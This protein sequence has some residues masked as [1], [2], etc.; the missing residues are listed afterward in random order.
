MEKDAAKIRAEMTLEEKA[1]FCSG[2]DFWHTKGIAR[3]GIP[4]VAVSDGPHGLR[5]TGKQDALGQSG[6]TGAV[7]FPSA[8]GTA[9]SFNRELLRE[10]GVSLGEEAQA[11][12]VRILLGPAVNIKRSPLG[13]RD[14]EYFSEDPY[15][16]GELAA[17]YIGGVQSQGVGACVKHFAAN[18]QET[19][20]LSVS[21]DMSQRTLR[22][23]YL[24]AFET[25]VKRSKPW[26]LMSSYNR[27]NGRYVQET[28]ELL[29]AIL[30]GEWG[31]DGLVM[32]DWSACDDRVASMK[33]GQDLEM[34]GGI[35]HNSHR[36]LEAVRSGRLPER[37]LDL[38]VERIL[39]VVIRVLEQHRP[40]AAYS[41]EEHHRR[42]YR[43]AL[44][45]MVLLKNEG[46][47]LPLREGSRVAFLG[48]FAKHP[49]F[50]GGGS[51]HVHPSKVDSAWKAAA[52]MAEL[53]FAQGYRTGRGA[54]ETALIA[55]AAEA[56][57][58]AE[59]AVIFAGLPE[60][61]ESEGRDRAG[62]ALPEDQNRLIA[63]V[64]AAQPNTVVVLHNGSP[65]AMPWLPQV[66]AVLE[67]Y[68]GGEAVGLA[69]AD[70]LFGRENP[71]GKLAETFPLRL[72]HTPCYLNFPGFDGSA[73]YAE[74]V[75]VGYR[76]YVSKHLP[77]LFPFGYGLSYTTF[78]YGGL[79]L[80]SAE[81][82]GEQEL[83]VTVRVKNTGGRAGREIVQLYVCP[84]TGGI[85][86]PSV[87]LKG[88]EQVEL[89][90]GEEKEV[91][92]LLPPRAFAFYDERNH[93][94]HVES[95]RY[96]V[97]IGRSSAEPALRQDVFWRTPTRKGFRVTRNTLLKE[98]A[99]HPVTCGIAAEE[100]EPLRNV[101]S[102]KP[103]ER[104]STEEGELDFD[105]GVIRD[106]IL[107]TPL[108]N[109]RGA[110]GMADEETIGR[111]IEKLN[112]ALEQSEQ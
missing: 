80:S 32:S 103:P 17:S 8:A 76:Y 94:W 54:D 10:I 75:F 25:A 96:T 19:S 77:V 49:R 81:L 6:S 83:R 109:V 44:E 86:R 71:C 92:F 21:A 28:P 12:D 3:L 64:A 57:R 48:E 40:G 65:V 79:T 24:P 39:R 13:G 100:L 38:A 59:T 22:E 41:R 90:P 20:R 102:G 7:C 84:R 69:Q 45:S 1:D 36:I 60:T 53:T 82:S 98:L 74:G 62:I 55:E 88:F 50:Q 26:T 18:S 58:S 47:L 42:A 37:V 66:K 67:S 51:S 68:L 30:R 23:I 46:G 2:L 52:G 93:G 5:Q 35:T 108:R 101:L 61:Y 73:D 43:A 107:E 31:F 56:A 78:E 106:M 99:A 85:P 105:P 95:G 89:Q 34:P 91:T 15:L 16:T 29:T 11:E 104:G 9:C 87:E 72:E 111:L 27:I 112:L 33:A 70:L 4:P 63:A 110:D 97:M 14:F